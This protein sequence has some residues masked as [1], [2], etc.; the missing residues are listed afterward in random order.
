MVLPGTIMTWGTAGAAM[1]FSISVLIA[2]PVL[3][4]IFM[5]PKSQTVGFGFKHEMVCS[6]C[7]RKFLN[8]RPVLS[9]EQASKDP[10]RKG[11]AASEYADLV[12]SARRKPTCTISCQQKPSIWCVS[13][14]G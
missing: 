10:F 9:A 13:P 12:T 7:F 3:A 8:G 1:N 14:L 6:S 5:Y 11:R 4:V 2:W